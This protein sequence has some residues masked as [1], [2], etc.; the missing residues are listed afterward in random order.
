[1]MISRTFLRRSSSRVM[2]RASIVLPRPT[3]SAMNRL[4]RGRSRALRSGSSW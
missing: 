2:S 1:M 4:T 3:S